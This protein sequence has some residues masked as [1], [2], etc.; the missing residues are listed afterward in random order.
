MSVLLKFS[1][2]IGNL[3]GPE[4]VFVA[5]LFKIIKIKKKKKH[6]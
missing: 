2:Q 5:D 4:K 1:K 3:F 6:K